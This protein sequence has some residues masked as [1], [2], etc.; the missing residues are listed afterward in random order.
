MTKA[1]ERRR[2]YLPVY[3]DGKQKTPSPAVAGKLK[4]ALLFLR[5]IGQQI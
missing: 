2:L 3:F 1:E 4:V 5:D